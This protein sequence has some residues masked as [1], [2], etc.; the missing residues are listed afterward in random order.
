MRDSAEPERA[1][2]TQILRCIAQQLA[3][4]TTASALRPAATK[5]YENLTE[6]G[7]RFK[8]LDLEQSA[9]LILD[10]TEGLKSV[11][12]IVDAM[13]E[14]ENIPILL[15]KLG[16]ILEQAKIPIRIF[17]ASRNLKAIS[18]RLEALPSSIIEMGQNSGDI[19]L[20]VRTEVEHAISEKSLLY[21]ELS[22]ESKQK[23]IE[24]LTA[25][26]QGM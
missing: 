4:N 9:M 23:I 15:T 5:K 20:F 14:C 17:I 24:T 19:S 18:V 10:L 1:D 13:D 6:G 25:G 3:Y 22:P 21:G 7:I 2:P 12:I 8:Q 11:T 26:A 16:W